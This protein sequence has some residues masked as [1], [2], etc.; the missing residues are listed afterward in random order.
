[1]RRASFNTVLK[2]QLDCKKVRE[3]SRPHFLHRRNRERFKARYELRKDW[4]K[5]YLGPIKRGRPLW[6]SLP[7]YEAKP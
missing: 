2:K 5:A 7:D 3:E 4:R 6:M 1:M